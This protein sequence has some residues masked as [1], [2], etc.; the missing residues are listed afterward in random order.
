MS[1]DQ[2]LYFEDFTVGRTFTTRGVTLS[3]AEIID[4]AFR[5]DPQPFH[6]DKLAAEQSAYGGLIASGFHTLSICFRMAIQ[7]E[8][9]TE[10]SM[11]SPGIDELRWLQPV[12]PGDTLYTEF[13]VIHAEPSKSRPQRG[14]VQIAYTVKN[15]RGE[16]VM[17]VTAH[18]IFRTRYGAREGRGDA[19]ERPAQARDST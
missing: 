2:P 10:C 19:D 4:F 12:R 16:A 5:Y 17:T 8:V 13:E 7:A 9:F 14:R 11:G 18:Q 6:I 15:Q 1:V 3:E